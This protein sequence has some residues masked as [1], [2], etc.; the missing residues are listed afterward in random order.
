MIILT[1]KCYCEVRII[2][3]INWL[4]K[5]AVFRIQHLNSNRE[6]LF[7]FIYF[8]CIMLQEISWPILLAHI[9]KS[10]FRFRHVPE[11]SHSVHRGINPSPPQKHPPPSF[12]P[13]PMQI[14]QAPFLG[15]SPL[16][17]AFVWHPWPLKIGELP[18][19]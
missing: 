17:I 14:V 10:Y 6:E 18:Y 7:A 1:Q 19:Y 16:Y 2:I 4:F 9:I 3:A 13:S 8:F 11:L 5:L 12:L 15:N